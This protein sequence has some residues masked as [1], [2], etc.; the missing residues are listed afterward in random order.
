MVK[1]TV[2]TGMGSQGREMKLMSWRGFFFG[3]GGRVRGA[4]RSW[5]AG[6]QTF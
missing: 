4:E 2:I 5:D 1:T 6:Q 3:G